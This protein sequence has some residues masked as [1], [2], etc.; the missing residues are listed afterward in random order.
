MKKVFYFFFFILISTCALY[1]Q[2]EKTNGPN[3][4]T[5]NVVSISLVGSN[6]YA[7]T[8]GQGVY[9]SKNNGSDWSSI[10]SGLTDPYVFYITTIGSS[11]Y[12]ATRAGIYL[13]T[14]EGGN[15]TRLDNGGLLNNVTSIVLIDPYIYVSCY[16]G[17]FGIFL[18][19]NNEQNWVAH[20]I[21]LT[22]KNVNSLLLVGNDV[23]AG[24]DGG[25]VFKSSVGINAWSNVSA[26][27]S[28][29]VDVDFLSLSNSNLLAGT[30][31]GMYKSE[32][33]GLNWVQINSG[34]TNNSGQLVI[35]TGIAVYKSNIFIST[36]GDGIFLSSDS[37]QSWSKINTGLSNLYI[38]SLAV[39][40]STIYIGVARETNVGSIVYKRP[41]SE[42][43]T[44]VEK[45][46]STIPLV[47][48]LN[49]NCPNPF[50]PTTNISY[51]IPQ[52][53]NVTLKVYDLLGREVVELV[54][55]EKNPGRYEVRFDG[56]NLTS[57]V[58]FYR[59]TAG[60]FSQ[61]K[62]LMLIK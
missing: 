45:D 22:N 59:L 47:Y 48:L 33:N 30:T 11:I 20:N 12:T 52:S 57:G 14:N 4:L 62:K 24:T 37:G 8:S 53:A 5:S 55:G 19:K 42:V 13:S 36:W 6:I 58:Y 15:W 39:S 28:N 56:S 10:N 41:V 16:G 60:S 25:G 49:Q 7:G 38:S 26:G 32:D 31:Q 3:S 1:A 23:F 29:S 61:T 46:I 34:L 40:N 54:N 9:F 51:S 50:N 44:N 21:G 43:I 35:V 17:S 2:W 27:L 18:N